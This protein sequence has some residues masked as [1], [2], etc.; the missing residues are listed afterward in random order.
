MA[1]FNTHSWIKPP[2]K[3]TRPRSGGG[4][5][6]RRQN[7]VLDLPDSGGLIVWP[8]VLWSAVRI[9]CGECAGQ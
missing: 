5:E 6:L 7:L 1:A 3:P 4:G 8:G 9:P 2:G